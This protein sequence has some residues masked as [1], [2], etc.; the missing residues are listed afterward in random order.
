MGLLGATTVVR[1]TLDPATRLFF[2]TSPKLR[3]DFE[4]CLFAI[5]EDIASRHPGADADTLD[6]HLVEHFVE[7][8]E[9]DPDAVLRGEPT[10]ALIHFFKAEDISYPTAHIRGIDDVH[11]FVYALYRTLLCPV[12]RCGT[13]RH[14]RGVYGE[15]Q[16][17]CGGNA[18]ETLCRSLKARL[19]VLQVTAQ[20]AHM[21]NR[22]IILNHVYAHIDAHSRLLCAINARI[23][24]IRDPR[25]IR[26]MCTDARL[27]PLLAANP[28]SLEWAF[29]AESVPD[30]SL[31]LPMAMVYNL[32]ANGASNKKLFQCKFPTTPAENI[33]RMEKLHKLIYKGLPTRCYNRQL[34]NAI[35]RCCVTQNTKL[36]TAKIDHEFIVFF[37]KII[38]AAVLGV[39]TTAQKLD[40]IN[41]RVLVYS[42][43]HSNIPIASVLD[44]PTLFN[45]LALLYITREYLCEMISRAPGVIEA[46]RQAYN[47][48]INIS[49]ISQIMATVRMQVRANL[50]KVTRYAPMGHWARVVFT[51]VDI[52]VQ[53]P[54]NRSRC[55]QREKTV[56]YD[57]YA[58][59]K[60]MLDMNLKKHVVA[61]ESQ[62]KYLGREFLMEPPHPVL[63]KAREDAMRRVIQTFA[64]T[65]YVPLEWLVC[66][67]AKWVDVCAVQ[68]A[69]FGKMAHLMKILRTMKE[70]DPPS[71]ALFF[72]FFVL[73]KEHRDYR[74]YFCDAYMYMRH[75][76]V[77][78]QVHKVPVGGHIPQVL[79]K[80][81][82]C[83]S[84]KDVKRM[85]FFAPIKRNT[86]GTGII[87]IDGEG[88][89]VCGRKHKAAG[90]R[91]LLKAASGG[92]K[93]KKDGDE[94]EEEGE[95]EDDEAIPDADGEDMG[96][97][98]QYFSGHLDYNFNPLL[99]IKMDVDAENALDDDDDFLPDTKT[100]IK[101]PSERVR[102][103]KVARHIALQ[104]TL[105]K[106]HSQKLHVIRAMGRIAVYQ[107][108]VYILCTRCLRPLPLLQALDAGLDKI[109]I[110]CHQKE[111]EVAISKI[112]C[113][114]GACQNKVLAP[115]DV[116]KITAYDDSSANPDEHCLRQ[117]T[118]CRAHASF[119]WVRTTDTVL[120]TSYLFPGLTAGWGTYKGPNNSYIPVV[121]EDEL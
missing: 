104:H 101:V 113:E 100:N 119:Q 67:G 20:I 65:A 44:V 103:R 49:F 13:V 105:R 78:H 82:V 118:L 27:A 84:C 4:E 86:D 59:V 120:C 73:C 26:M 34:W 11:L 28:I 45:K 68:S 79:G 91:E 19:S 69:L 66:F 87:R 116:C 85:S 89:I 3:N 38:V 30:T 12:E 64:K 108:T 48:D 31:A 39:Y 88:E 72:N 57:V 1:A 5:R 7:N 8:V 114:A 23:S 92:E 29:T 52:R 32:P 63:T 61:M 77:L 60:N 16:C 90:W 14:Y 58:I 80:I 96:I 25:E 15:W 62:G 17:P 18:C 94:E 35:R 97:F 46:L 53:A 95:D 42:A 54:H 111:R 106:C 99:D 117:V 40:D 51:G 110:E 43:I 24:E 2:G 115:A 50:A 10:V 121:P 76:A 83:P 37:F 47:W 56:G 6:D 102:R 93:E 21:N 75:A 9:Y 33:E 70:T 55:T 98:A 112:R 74:E 22:G 36:R 81:L 109:C 71:Y 41:S 107:R